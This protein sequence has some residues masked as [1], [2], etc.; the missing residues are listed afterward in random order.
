MAGPGGV[1]QAGAVV[2]MDD[3]RARR[4][5]AGGYAVEEPDQEVEPV[6][7]VPETAEAPPAPETAMGQPGRKRARRN[8]DK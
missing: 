3:E 1:V 5:V 2:E 8:S 7:E 4:L 6:I